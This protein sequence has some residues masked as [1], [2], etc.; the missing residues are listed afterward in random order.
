MGCSDRSS[1]P[2][3][4]KRIGEGAEGRRQTP[5]KTLAHQPQQL[6]QCLNPAGD[7]LEVDATHMPPSPGEPVGEE[8]VQPQE[9]GG[10]REDGEEEVRLAAENRPKDTKIPDSR[11]PGPV[12]QEATRQAQ[13]DEGDEDDNK[14]D[15]N[16]SSRH[17]HLPRVYVRGAS[18]SIPGIDAWADVTPVAASRSSFSSMFST[19]MGRAA[20]TVKYRAR[21][22]AR[23]TETCAPK[24]ISRPWTSKLRRSP[25][26][27]GLRSSR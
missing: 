13:Y 11:E 22:S 5:R 10:P 26:N 12:N 24:P 9:G 19:R 23:L 21:N 18:T 16:A 27:L 2:H 25:E 17:I 14:S 15:R 1:V 3:V 4:R 20:R 8:S 7:L 6:G